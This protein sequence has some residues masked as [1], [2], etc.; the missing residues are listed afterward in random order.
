MHD[1]ALRALAE[2][3]IA[4][5]PDPETRNELSALL[6]AGALGE[7]RARMTPP[8]VFGTAG[9]RAKVGAG[10]ARMNRATVIRAT[11]GLA[12]FLAT[13]SGARVLPVVG[14]GARPPTTGA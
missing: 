13:R 6:A 7:V 14:R 3:W 1:E 5:D 10:A 8:L 2:A 12:D 4:G 11:R 9:L